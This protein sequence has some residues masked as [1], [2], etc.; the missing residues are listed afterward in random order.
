MWSTWAIR[1]SCQ[2]RSV[3]WAVAHTWRTPRVCV[4]NFKKFIEI[5]LYHTP[6]ESVHSLKPL[7][8]WVSC[9]ETA[10]LS[11]YRLRLLR[12]LTG[13]QLCALTGLQLCAL[14]CANAVS[15]DQ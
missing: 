7:M 1:V 6:E 15:F 3:V 13:L 8:F 5:V 9:R 14:A 10:F 12:L 4:V 11:T 2:P